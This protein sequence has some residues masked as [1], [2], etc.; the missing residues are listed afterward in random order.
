MATIKQVVNEAIERGMTCT[1]YHYM[2]Y[3][4]IY[5]LSSSNADPHATTGPNKADQ[6]ST[7]SSRRTQCRE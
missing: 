5:S 2:N 4:N 1:L 3:T 6:G 7:Y